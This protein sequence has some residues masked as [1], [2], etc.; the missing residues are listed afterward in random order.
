MLKVA[1][2]IGCEQANGD[3]DS[4]RPKEDL[5]VSLTVGRV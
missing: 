1:M 2:T 3:F 4:R 5:R